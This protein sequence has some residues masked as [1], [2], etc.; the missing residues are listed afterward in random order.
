MVRELGDK[1]KLDQLGEVTV[2]FLILKENILAPLGV[3]GRF[4]LT[5]SV[6]CC[7]LTLRDTYASK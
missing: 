2:C 7:S 6:D 1:I 4:S 5:F 3:G